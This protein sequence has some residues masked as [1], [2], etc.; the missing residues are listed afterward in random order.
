MAGF[1]M[2]AVMNLEEEKDPE[3]ATGYGTCTETT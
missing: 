1:G 2:E 3:H